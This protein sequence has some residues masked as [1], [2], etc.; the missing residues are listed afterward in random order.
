MLLELREN[1]LRLLYDHAECDHEALL[2]ALTAYEMPNTDYN[3]LLSMLGN[4]NKFT[5][6]TWN[7]ETVPLHWRK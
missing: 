5:K 4:M 7:L 3:E 2:Q 6:Q 1:A